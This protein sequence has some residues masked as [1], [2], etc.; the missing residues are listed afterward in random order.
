[1]SEKKKSRFKKQ[2]GREVQEAKKELISVEEITTY[3][4][5][6]AD[7]SNWEV[8]EEKDEDGNVIMEDGEPVVVNDFIDFSDAVV[9]MGGIDTLPED[10]AEIVREV[11]EELK[12]KSGL[13]KEELKEFEKYTNRIA[14]YESWINPIEEMAYKVIDG[15]TIANDEDETIEEMNNMI[16]S[17]ALVVFKDLD[18]L[19]DNIKELNDILN[20][21]SAIAIEKMEETQRETEK[22]EKEFNETAGVLQ[23][24]DFQEKMKRYFDFVKEKGKDAAEDVAAGGKSAWKGLGGLIKWNKK[25]KEEFGSTNFEEEFEEISNITVAFPILE[26]S[27][28]DMEKVMESVTGDYLIPIKNSSM[29][30]GQEQTRVARRLNYYIA[31]LNEL[32]YRFEDQVIP[33][34]KLNAEKGNDVVYDSGLK[35]VNDALRYLSDRLVQLQS[36]QTQAETMMSILSSVKDNVKA[37][38]GRAKYT[39]ETAIPQYRTMMQ[40][41]NTQIQTMKVTQNFAKFQDLGSK[42]INAAGSV[43]QVTEKLNQNMSTAAMAPEE[44]K[45]LTDTV[46]EVRASKAEHAR[47]AHQQNKKN[48]KMLADQSDAVK[49]A[50]RKASEMLLTDETE[51]DKADNKKTPKKG[52]AKDEFQETA[53]KQAATASNDDQDIS[54]DQNA[55]TND[56]AARLAKVKARRSGKKPNKS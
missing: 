2:R 26:R 55:E 29:E 17:F 33:Q 38:E 12:E 50:G 9:E 16:Q 25:A 27:L 32:I 5:E 8:Y 56:R 31:A 34:A 21:N 4:E 41:I 18:T 13:S 35:A 11:Y 28:S 42:I 23:D 40:S 24:E 49:E 1:M 45:K 7:K 3:L 30:V 22:A 10:K 37:L 51:D 52:A 39:R 20:E 15:Q 46:N 36:S 47:L 43:M 19:G 14:I 6:L 53:E 54:A 44:L 48:A